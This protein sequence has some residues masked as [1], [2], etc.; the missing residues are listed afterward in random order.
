M[1]NWQTDNTNYLSKTHLGEGGDDPSQARSELV[2]LLDEVN[3]IL[4]TRGVANGIC[5]LD[6]SAK[7]PAARLVDVIDSDQLRADAVTQ[8]KIAPSSVS[9]DKLKATVTN[10]TTP[11]T[12]GSPG[13]MHFI[14]VS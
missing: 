12:G 5:D 6:E 7:V 3:E 8:E 1:A 2:A 13:D 9:F 11:P 10:E 4:K 14:Y